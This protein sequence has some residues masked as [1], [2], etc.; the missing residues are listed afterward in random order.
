MVDKVPQDQGAA[1][2]SPTIPAQI[3]SLHQKADKALTHHKVQIA[4][5]IAVLAVVLF[6]AFH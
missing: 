5:G 1:G 2:G 4:I 3:A 6:V